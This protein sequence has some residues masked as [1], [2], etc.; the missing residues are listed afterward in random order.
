MKKWCPIKRNFQT[1]NRAESPASGVSG[2]SIERRALFV[3]ATLGSLLIGCQGTGNQPPIHTA[4]DVSRP[5][6]P[7]P[8]EIRLETAKEDTFRADSPEIPAAG[9]AAQTEEPVLSEPSSIL[10]DALAEQGGAEASRCPTGRVGYTQLLVIPETPRADQPV[11]V[12][13]VTRDIEEEMTL[14]LKTPEGELVPPSRDEVWGHLPKAYSLYYPT[15][16]VGTYHAEL[17]KDD[18]EVVCL[19]VDVAAADTGTHATEEQV[20]VWP[21]KH[22][23]DAAWEDVYSI[24][25][26]KLFYVEPGSRKG[27]KPL[28]QAPRDP[29]RN[30]LYGVLGWDEDNPKSE[31]PVKLEPDCGDAPYH[32][33]AYFAWKMGLPFMFHWCSRGTSVKGPNCNTTFSNR[34]KRFDDI[35]DPVDRFN[36][37]AATQIG[38][39]VH[40]GN[41][42]TLPNS[43][44]T[45]FYPVPLTAESV[46]P[47]A[48]FVDAGGH[49][50]LVSQVEPQTG[51]AMGALYGVDSHPDRTVTHKRF[52]PGTFVFNHR[53]PTDGF[54]AFRP[55]VEEE[56]KLRFLSNS[57]INA[58]GDLTPAT[59]V[60]AK[61]ASTE[62]FY[63]TM[64]RVLNP[65]PVSP[66]KVLMSKIEVLHTAIKERAEAVQVGVE[67]MTQIGW[68]KMSMPD[69]PAIF[70]TT[71]PWE[72]YS[73]PAR[74]MRCFLAI[75]DVM[76]FVNHVFKN[77]PLYAVDDTEDLH[78]LRK[79][80]TALRDEALQ[81]RTV[82]YVRSDGSKW[83]LTLEEV[84]SRQKD[85][86]MAY[87]PNDCPE[88]RWAAPKD[89]DEART[90]R[91]KAPPD[92]RFKMRLA[93]PWFEARRRPD[94]R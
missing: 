63:H 52:G 60:Q 61:L 88:T 42:R 70:Q 10:E 38:W 18:G 58:E 20:G 84:V 59:P 46:R 83:T 72:I 5:T 89:S 32:M 90:C 56:R 8:Q 31:H 50:I 48:V 6:P 54:K 7:V 17:R 91:R 87:N 3:I 43:D 29:F 11:R 80:L 55:V 94:Q 33:R 93:R 14:T 35:A 12:L 28:H 76:K 23:W 45:D 22:S 15:L 9:L 71:G 75:D 53:V 68:R 74:D 13:A 82:Q 86:E 64:N 1:R 27:W 2:I 19:A 34:I 51:S 16:E 57:E 67:Y 49:V 62:T 69:G 65:T 36:A 73:T 81:E 30:I 44:A 40:S 37:F 24:F 21:V 26:A 4:A 85:L 77:L 39:K 66:Q 41:A 47:G 78:K 25:I 79:E 92:Q